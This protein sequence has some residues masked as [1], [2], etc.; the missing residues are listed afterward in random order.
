MTSI[1]YTINIKSKR[2]IYG[3]IGAFITLMIPFFLMFFNHNNHLETDQS[4]CPLKMLTGFPCPGCGITKSLV[5]F[6]EG[7]LQ[8]SLYYHILGPLVIVFCVVTIVVLTTE[9][10][11]K[12]EYF[13]N[14]LF[15]KKLAYGLGIFLATYHF[16]RIIYF[17]RNNSIDDILHQSIWR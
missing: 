12:K 14:L 17:I 13:N 4:L 2:K 7:D 9:L 6:Y 16:I 15:N 1:N 11:T 3:I 5:Y 8:K 10:I